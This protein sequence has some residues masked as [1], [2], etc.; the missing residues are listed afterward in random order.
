MQ[1][2]PDRTDLLVDTPIIQ[3]GV[4]TA[5]M[6]YGPI[7]CTWRFKKSFTMVIQMLLRGEAYKLSSV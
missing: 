6:P 3:R 2:Q 7:P 1:N 5:D 4:Q